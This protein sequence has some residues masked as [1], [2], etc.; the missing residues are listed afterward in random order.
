M[1]HHQ[2]HE[3]HGGFQEPSTR[4]TPDIPRRIP[5]QSFCASGS[6]SVSFVI[7]VVK[8]AQD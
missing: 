1:F 8:N 5:A 2:G 6:V 7:F 3:Y 4:T